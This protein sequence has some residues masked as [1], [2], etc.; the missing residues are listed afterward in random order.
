MESL[1]KI[2]ALKI[3]ANQYGCFQVGEIFELPDND[4]Q[5]LTMDGAA[6]EVSYEEAAQLDFLHELYDDLEHIQTKISQVEQNKTP[7][8]MIIAEYEAYKDSKKKPIPE[9]EYAAF[10]GKAK[11]KVTRR[12]RTPVANKDV[13]NEQHDHDN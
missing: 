13:T 12:R 8:Q 11:K 6:E 2:K 10:A 4:A 1:T 9:E 5:M 3:I 7:E